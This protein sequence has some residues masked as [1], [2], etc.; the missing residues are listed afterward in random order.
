[1][2]FR[3]AIKDLYG[4]EPVVGIGEEMDQNQQGGLVLYARALI[5]DGYFKD[6]IP[7]LG[8][9]IED[10]LLKNAATGITSACSPSMR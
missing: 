6:H 4:F 8:Q 3:S 1:M 10:G 5:V 7:E 9:I 2:L